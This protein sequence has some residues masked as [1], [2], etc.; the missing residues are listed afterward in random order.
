MA[1]T[2]IDMDDADAAKKANAFNMF[3]IPEG[4]LADPYP[5]FRLLRDHDPVHEN[6]DGSLLITRYADVKEVWR[7]LTAVVDKRD[8]F[9]A[10]FGEG[11]LLE[12]HTTGMLFRDPPDHDRLRAIVNPFFATQSVASLRPVVEKLT[13]DLL[14][15]FE[16]GVEIEFVG[17]VAFKLTI[18]VICNMLGVPVE[19]GN[20]IQQYGKRLLYPLNPSVSAQ[21]IADGH[22][23]VALFKDYLAGHLARVRSQARVDGSA[24]ILSALVDAERRGADIS[25]TEILH[26]CII[27][28]NGG[29]ESTTNLIAMSIHMLLEHPDQLAL[30]RA[31]G[32]DIHVAIEELIRFISPIQFQGRRITRPT[33]LSGTDIAPNTEI[34]FGVASANHDDRVFDAPERLD[35]TRKPNAHIGFGAGV[36]VCIG[37]ALAKLE[38]SI[39]LPAVMRHFPRIERAGPALYAP[40]IRFRGLSALPLRLYR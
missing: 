24:N 2:T 20:R 40:S 18:A 32:D 39:V 8:Q 34:V 38:T 22:E 11:P 28:L 4:Y 15:S 6:P 17:D 35:L 36:H 3:A 5:W 9:R 33:T 27:A 29:H 30:F 16:D 7:D 12:H 13:R 31:A 23:A 10:K 26:M 19:D 37:R 1:Q 25:E 14:D 21:D